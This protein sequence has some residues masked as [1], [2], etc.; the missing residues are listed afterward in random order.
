MARGASLRQYNGADSNVPSLVLT[1]LTS[2]WTRIN[3]SS[4]RSMRPSTRTERS[5]LLRILPSLT[6]RQF[7]SVS[8]Y[9]FLCQHWRTPSFSCA[10]VLLTPIIFRLLGFYVCQCFCTF[11]RRLYCIF[12]YFASAYILVCANNLLAPIFW[13][14]KVKN[15]YCSNDYELC[16][17][18]LLLLSTTSFPM[19]ATLTQ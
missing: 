4:R 13:G 18:W 9:F 6:V 10:N 1:H 14:F 15:D 11:Y 16:M 12:V 3:T 7:F 5:Q 17:S 2:T 8:A 19:I